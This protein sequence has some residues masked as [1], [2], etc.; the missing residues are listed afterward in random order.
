MVVGDWDGNV[1]PLDDVSHP[2]SGLAKTCLDTVSVLSYRV[3]RG[4]GLDKAILYFATSGDG[5]VLVDVRVSLNK[6]VGPGMLQDVW[7][8]VLRTQ[9]IISIEV[10]KDAVFDSIV[11][12][13]EP[14]SPSLILKPSRF[15]YASV[16]ND[17]VP[18]Y[19]EV[20]R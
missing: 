4:I 11:A 10:L 20:M 6:F 2:L 18:L 8:K 1:V 9:E 5:L 13:R 3:V 7:G 16:G 19:V 14:Y 12:G 17:P 15:R